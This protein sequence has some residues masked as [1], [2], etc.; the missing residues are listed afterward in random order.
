MNGLRVKKDYLEPKLISVST[1]LPK[2]VFLLNP[3][4]ALMQWQSVAQK[5]EGLSLILD[6]ELVN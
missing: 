6:G 5:P 1:S 3:S 2:S 4:T